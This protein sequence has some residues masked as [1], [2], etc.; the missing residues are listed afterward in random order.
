[1][2]I[3]TLVT[4]YNRATLSTDQLAA[5]ATDWLSHK[6]STRTAA[7]RL[8]VGF[9]RGRLSLNESSHVEHIVAALQQWEQQVRTH[10]NVL[11]R[12]LARRHPRTTHSLFAPNTLHAHSQNAQ[13][14]PA[15]IFAPQVCS[16]LD[17]PYR[18]RIHI[19]I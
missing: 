11:A 16:T 15:P 10:V 8:T 2:N 18:F 4:N 6:I 9:R 14:A 5:I 3:H 17:S 7:R 12:V 19:L 13:P 1:M